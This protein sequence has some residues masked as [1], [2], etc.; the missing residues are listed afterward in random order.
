MSSGDHRETKLTSDFLKPRW[1]KFRDLAKEGNGRKTGR[2]ADD[3]GGLKGED[4]TC[5]VGLG[6]EAQ[7]VPARLGP[8]C[9]HLLSFLHR[10]KVGWSG[11]SL[12]L[13][14]PLLSKS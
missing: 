9:S 6:S 3:T 2:G 7:S 4:G 10:G 14:L 1:E 8:P 13:G 11:R 12:W 5:G